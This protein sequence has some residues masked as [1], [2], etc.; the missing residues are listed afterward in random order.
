[1][2]IKIAGLFLVMGLLFTLSTGVYAENTAKDIGEE[3]FKELCAKCHPD[4]ANIVNPK[5]TL[6]KTVRESNNIKSADDIIRLMRNPGP[7]MTTF[8]EKYFPKDEAQKI[9]DYVLK[10]FN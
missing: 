7:G 9:A 2:T 1:M 3:K 5:K 10:T 6:H 8:P 4:G